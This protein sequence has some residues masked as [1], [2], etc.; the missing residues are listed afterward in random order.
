M[1]DED[2]QNLIYK[3]EKLLALTL[4]LNQ[5]MLSLQ[6]RTDTALS[7]VQ[8]PFNAS[9]AEPGDESLAPYAPVTP[10]FWVSFDHPEIFS[11]RLSRMTPSAPDLEG[12]CDLRFTLDGGESAT[13][14]ALEYA[15]PW[16]ELRP[17]ECAAITLFASADSIY[18]GSMQ[19]FYWLD[20]GARETLLQDNIQF[21]LD[22]LNLACKVEAD[23]RLSTD[24][25]INFDR[26]PVLAI[27]LDSSATSYTVSDLFVAIS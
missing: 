3:S 24:A 16:R 7:R 25:R 4:Q 8:E 22:E 26:D 10:H 2:L 20:D 27:F 5:E 6:G 21:E 18:E 17:A 13:W 19:I 23:I 12:R 1:H 14:F 11:C 15:L 9:F